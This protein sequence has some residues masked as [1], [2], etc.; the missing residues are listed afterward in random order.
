MADLNT[1]VQQLC[2][3]A[4]NEVRASDSDRDLTSVSISTERKTE[5][6]DKVTTTLAEQVERFAELSYASSDL[7]ADP[8]RPGRR[9]KGSYLDPADIIPAGQESSLVC[10]F[11]T[12][13]LMTMSGGGGQSLKTPV[14]SLEVF[15]KVF[16][17]AR[18]AKF[19]YLAALIWVKAEQCARESDAFTLEMLYPQA[20]KEQ[21]EIYVKN[22]LAEA[23]GVNVATVPELKELVDGKL[24]SESLARLYCFLPRTGQPK[25]RATPPTAVD[26]AATDAAPRETAQPDTLPVA[27]APETVSDWGS[28]ATVATGAN[29][30][31]G[32]AP[33]SDAED[34]MP[35]AADIK[36]T[37]GEAPPPST[38]SAASAQPL[39][40]DVRA[41]VPAACFSDPFF[42]GLALPLGLAAVLQAFQRGDLMGARQHLM[43]ATARVVPRSRDS[44]VAFLLYVRLLQAEG[45][46]GDA[47][48]GE[49]RALLHLWEEVVQHE[50]LGP[51]AVLGCQ[52]RLAT[53]DLPLIQELLRLTHSFL[54]RRSAEASLKVGDTNVSLKFLEAQVVTLQILPFFLE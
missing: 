3:A 10:C 12:R 30:A 4:L 26:Q 37:A 20:P 46:Q 7:K 13:N 52:T 1:F 45:L 9:P 31:A 40:A 48:A 15:R 14:A 34:A 27:A 32:A 51:G 33:P 17:L 53:W 36:T 29:P 2:K 16:R 41:P 11:L 50:V 22:L 23:E 38:V 35:A 43:Q 44:F 5:G 28:D 19:N 42:D 24:V 39:R 54:H 18:M 25:N 6:G 8:A 21:D 47:A 49:E